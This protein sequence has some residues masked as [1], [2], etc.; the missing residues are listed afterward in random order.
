MQ[1][2]D[3]IVREIKEMSETRGRGQNTHIIEKVK[4]LKEQGIS[5]NVIADMLSISSPMARYY[6]RQEVKSQEE[7]AESIA[8]CFFRQPREVQERIAKEIG[9]ELPP[10]K[11]IVGVENTYKQIEKAIEFD[12]N[13]LFVRCEKFLRGKIP[14][15]AI[16]DVFN[17]DE[18]QELQKIGKFVSKSKEVLSGIKSVYT[19]EE[20]LD[21]LMEKGIK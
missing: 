15:N 9:Y 19:I 17:Q 8:T 12:E 21:E 11:S 6:A 3:M 16:E 14:P 2:M 13:S 5:I 20:V 10:E 7:R 4:K 1:T 18:I